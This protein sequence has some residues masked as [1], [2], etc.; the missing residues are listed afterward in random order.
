MSRP[1]HSVT[2]RSAVSIY[3][4]LA[5]ARGNRAFREKLKSQYVAVELEE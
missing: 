3:N 4:S 5:I 2:I 1:A